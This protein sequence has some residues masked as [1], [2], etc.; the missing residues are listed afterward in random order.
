MS[1]T[2]GSPSAGV[3]S[4]SEQLHSVH[5]RTVVVGRDVDDDQVLTCLVDRSSSPRLLSDRPIASVLDVVVQ[6]HKVLVTLTL[7]WLV[8]ET[9][10]VVGIVTYPRF[11]P[12][13]SNY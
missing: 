1:S 4:K 13:D 8:G 3:A 7:T 5:P 6:V 12:A 10:R 9:Q 2:G 11:L